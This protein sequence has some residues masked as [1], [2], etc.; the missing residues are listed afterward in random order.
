MNAAGG[1]ENMEGLLVVRE[2]GSG[3]INGG[4]N[5]SYKRLGSVDRPQQY[6][7]TLAA[8]HDG[9]FAFLGQIIKQSTQLRLA[10]A[11]WSGQRFHDQH[12]NSGQIQQLIRGGFTAS[13][14]SVEC[15]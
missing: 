14:Q 5:G 3:E 2:N 13:R 15:H 8:P 10:S 7:M 1:S 12:S 11:A 9:G 4:D 6:T